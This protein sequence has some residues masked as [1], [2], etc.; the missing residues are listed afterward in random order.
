MLRFAVIIGVLAMCMACNPKSEEMPIARVMNEYLYASDLVGIVATGTLQADS[1][2]AVQA[3]IHN[4]IQQ[5][6]LVNKAKKNLSVQQQNFEQEIENYRNSLIIF[7]YQNALIEQ[8]VDTIVT[9]TEIENYYEANKQ[10]FLLRSNIVRVLFA[11]LE[12]YPENSRDRMIREKIKMKQTIYTL[13]FLNDLTGEQWRELSDF[14]EEIAPNYYLLGERWI[15]FN[16]L[17]KEVPVE[18]YNPSAGIYNEEDFLRKNKK[19]QVPDEDYVYYVN[20][21][22]YRIRGNFSPIE[23]EREKIRNIILNNRKV[24]LI[25]SLRSEVMVEGQEKNWFE[26]Y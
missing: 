23:F 10:L 17:L 16:D 22:E 12:N 26:I 21:L 13:I 4:W 1:I 9:E 7:T 2:E 25:E 5:K 11:K 3:Y 24:A 6:L 15:Y 14:C 19:F 20:I 18:I 8:A